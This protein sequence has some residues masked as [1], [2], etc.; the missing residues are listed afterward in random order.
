LGFAANP[1]IMLLDA[2]GTKVR[3][4]IGVVAE[5]ELAVGLDAL[6]AR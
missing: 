1:Q 3:Q 6:I 4:W 2:K 5:P